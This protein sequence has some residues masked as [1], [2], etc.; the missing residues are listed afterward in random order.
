ME[1]CIIW[2]QHRQNRPPTV[3]QSMT[4]SS[5]RTLLRQENR[6]IHHIIRTVL[7]FRSAIQ[8]IFLMHWISRTDFRRFIHLEPY[9]MHF[10][11]RSCQAGNQQQHLC[12]RSRKITVCRIIH[13]LRHTL[14]A[15]NTVTLQGNILPVRSAA[16]SLRYT[17]G[18]L[19][20]IVRFRT[21][22]MAKHRNIRTANFMM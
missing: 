18:S 17:A 2:K 21:G 10:W 5:I 6:E 13:F 1:I 11:V 9:S 14:Y 19:V 22:M 7:I 16:K 8:R 3:W 12:V 15:K 4:K 20:I